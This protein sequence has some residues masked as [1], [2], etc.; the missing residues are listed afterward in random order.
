[1]SPECP[2]A[3]GVIESVAARSRTRFRQRRPTPPALTPVLRRQASATTT[4][5]VP[6]EART[7]SPDS[8]TVLDT[9]GGRG[10]GQRPALR[11]AAGD[12]RAFLARCAALPPLAGAQPPADRAGTSR[13]HGDDLDVQDRRR[14]GAGPAGLRPVHLDRRRLH[15]PDRPG[16]DPRIRGRLSGRLDRRALPAR[17][18]HPI[19]LSSAEPLP[20]L[21]RPSQAG[22]PD[23]QA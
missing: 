23:F 1:R 16:R 22:R 5:R 3:D 2:S 12:L 20:R 19:L 7:E 17:P 15:R 9:G 13:R 6:T 18:P 4:T 8:I 10:A 14:P 11:A 21:L